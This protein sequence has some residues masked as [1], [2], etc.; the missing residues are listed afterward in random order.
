[1]EFLN[2]DFLEN[3][4]IKLVLYRASPADPVK[5]RTTEQNERETLK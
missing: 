5:N 4:G 1:M 2:T 3:D